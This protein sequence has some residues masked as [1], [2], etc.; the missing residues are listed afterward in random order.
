MTMLMYSYTH[1]Q[2]TQQTPSLNTY[3]PANRQPRCFAQKDVLLFSLHPSIHPSILKTPLCHAINIM[4][5]ETRTLLREKAIHP[6]TV[7]LS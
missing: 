7:L 6:Y 4:M 2:T 3:N 5:W 1:I